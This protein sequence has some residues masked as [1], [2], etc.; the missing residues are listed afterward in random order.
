MRVSKYSFRPSD[1]TD[2]TDLSARSTAIPRSCLCPLISIYLGG[3]EAS[4]TAVS[5]ASANFYIISVF[6]SFRLIIVAASIV[7]IIV[8]NANEVAGP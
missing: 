3:G 5:R 6:V 2:P 1:R 8:I 7:I 4:I